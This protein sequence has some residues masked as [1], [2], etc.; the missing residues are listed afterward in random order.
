MENPT[1]PPRLVRLVVL[2]R[3]VMVR[4]WC[5][6]EAPPGV[7]SVHPAPVGALVRRSYTFVY[8]SYTFVPRRLEVYD[9][10]RLLRMR[11]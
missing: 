3:L 1:T 5:A 2:V 9:H 4:P 11:R 10:D 8:P 6:L 7:R